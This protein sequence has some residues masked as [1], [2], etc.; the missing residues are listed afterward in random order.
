MAFVFALT[1]ALG[2]QML[3]P[4]WLARPVWKPSVA[5]LFSFLFFFLPRPLFGFSVELEGF[6]ERN[7][8]FCFG[9]WWSAS[10]LIVWLYSFTISSLTTLRMLLLLVV[11]SRAYRDFTV[12]PFLP[13]LLKTKRISKK[14]SRSL[15]LSE[16]S[17][18][19]YHWIV[20][21]HWNIRFSEGNWGWGEVGSYLSQLIVSWGFSPAF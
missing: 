2:R 9:R 7:S 4:D 12:W 19:M 20:H 8:F 11:L 6:C 21:Y 17:F 14:F 1:L 3:A 13:F 15:S 10:L 18:T 5:F 16:R